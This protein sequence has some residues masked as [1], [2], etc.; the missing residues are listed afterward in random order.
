MLRLYP[1]SA[2]YTRPKRRQTRRFKESA[3]CVTTWL[4]QNGTRFPTW[5]VSPT[6]G[7]LNLGRDMEPSTST[8]LRY[9]LGDVRTDGT[10]GTGG[11]DC[12]RPVSFKVLQNRRRYDE[13]DKNISGEGLVIHMNF[14]N[15][16]T[17]YHDTHHNTY[18][19]LDSLART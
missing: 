10:G 4:P 15:F 1:L 3:R 2:A 9:A 14:T 12:A 13:I 16:A 6:L 7:G 8:P 5:N 17:A 11:T 19:R 18:T